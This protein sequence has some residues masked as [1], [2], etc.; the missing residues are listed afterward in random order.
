MNCLS[1]QIQQSQGSY[2]LQLICNDA[3]I[4][5]S[6]VG[7]VKFQHCNPSLGLC[8]GFHGLGPNHSA[9]IFRELVQILLLAKITVIL[10]LPGSHGFIM[11]F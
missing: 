9:V 10:S 4:L 5:I 8:E 11:D 2:Q 7:F 3:D 1:L 6:N